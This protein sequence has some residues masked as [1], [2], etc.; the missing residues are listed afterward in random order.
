MRQG[1]GIRTNLSDWRFS[2]GSVPPNER[3]SREGNGEKVRALQLSCS[4]CS[5]RGDGAKRCEQEKRRGGG[6]GG[7]SFSPASLS[8]YFSPALLL[9]HSTPLSQRLESVT[10]QTNR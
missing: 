4:R 8:P 6:E 10:P 3:R 2:V 1:Y 7:E 9:L 5:D